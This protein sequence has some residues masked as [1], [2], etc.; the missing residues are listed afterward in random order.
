MEVN[1][2][3]IYSD[4]YTWHVY[5]TIRF[6]SPPYTLQVDLRINSQVILSV[7][8]ILKRTEQHPLNYNV[9]Y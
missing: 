2:G 7:K 3:A 5:Y 9:L 8:L 6:Y 1:C 4:G